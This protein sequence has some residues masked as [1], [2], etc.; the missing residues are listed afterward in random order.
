MVTIPEGMQLEGMKSRLDPTNGVLT[1]FAPFSPP[2]IEQ[3]K[4]FHELP[5][6]HDKAKAI[7]KK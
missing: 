5:I 7:E 4:N 6:Q 2:A 1:V 3:K